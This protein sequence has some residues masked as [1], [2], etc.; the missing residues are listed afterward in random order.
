MEFP[1]LA[2]ITSVAVITTDIIITL[3][4]GAKFANGPIKI[5]FLVVL[6]RALLF[7]FGGN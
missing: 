7:G 5:V 2:P 3:L 6:I 1:Y 4:I